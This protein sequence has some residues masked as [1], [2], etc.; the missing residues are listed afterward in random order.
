MIEKEAGASL[1]F[2]VR[3]WGMDPYDSPL[4]SRIVSSIPC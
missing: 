3:E 1:W 2:L 4:R